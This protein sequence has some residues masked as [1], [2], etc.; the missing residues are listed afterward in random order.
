VKK[1]KIKKNKRQEIHPLMT[2]IIFIIITILL[3]GFLHLLDIQG[4]YY[5]INEFNLDLVPQTYIVK[6]LLSLSGIKYIFTSTV[7]NFA[8]FTVLSNLIILLMGISIMDKSGFLQTV[9]TL[10]TKKLRKKVVTFIFVF[11]CVLS[12]IFGNLSYL[13]FIPLG[14][15]LFYYG[16]RNP[17]IGIISSFAALSCGSGI[18]VFFT[19]VDSEL[20]NYTTIAAHTVNVNYVMHSF[21]FFLIMLLAMILIS[22]IITAVTENYIVRILPKYEFT[23]TELEEDIVT[24]DEK[25]GMTYACVSASIYLIIFI[26]N[27]IPG[28][29]FGGNF[30]DNSQVLYIDKLFSI[31]SFFSN[32]FVF[33]VTILF[34]ILGLFYGIGVKSI[35]NHNDFFD[36]LG[37]SLDGI[38]NMLVMIFLA[39]TFISIF[40]QSQIG[41]IIVAGIGNIISK[42]GFS[43]LPLIILVFLGVSISTLF[44]PSTELKWHILSSS[45]VPTMIKVEISPAFA[46]IIYRFAET[47]TLNITPLLAYFIVYLAFLEKYNQNNRNIKVIDA[48][49]YQISYTV[50]I[51]LSLLLVIIIWY[52]IG[53]P[54]GIKTF[55]VL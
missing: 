34:V 53:L 30:L 39:S 17:A 42:S 1:L 19:S 20:L 18:N 3:S 48:I 9:I 15:L 49:K 29:P 24:K 46:Q 26:Y 5:K 16:K 33:I 7:S 10:T 12:S 2:Y 55:P 13:I 27:I 23:E 28:L 44:V 32:G 6:S 40:K 25:K 4:T 22:Y 35:K 47:S 51:G 8:N 38:G 31:N 14:A 37:H 43:G 54:L 36:N 21:P 50:V 52:L 41:N 45:I 11:I